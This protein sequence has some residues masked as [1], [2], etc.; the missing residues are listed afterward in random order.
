M[1]KIFFLIAAVLFSS[2]ASAAS[3]TYNRYEKPFIFIENGIEFAVFNDGQFDFNIINSSNVNFNINTRNINFSF[4]TGHNYNA[5]VQ[6]D[7]YGAVVQIESTPVYYDNFGRV[8]R[9]GT[10]RMY[11]N[12]LGYASRIGNLYINYNNYGIYSGHRGAINTYQCNFS[13]RHNYYRLPSRDRCIVNTSPYRRDYT[14]RRYNYNN[15]SRHY[16]ERPRRYNQTSKRV[17]YESERNY[18]K[19]NYNKNVTTSRNNNYNQRRHNNN[20]K[21]YLQRQP[22]RKQTKSYSNRYLN[23]PKKVVKRSYTPRRTYASNTN[24]RTYKRK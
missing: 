1:K 9:I 23:T 10:T 15:Y 3:T 7:N 21:K 18:N 4:N 14:V 19:R 24:S 2:I 5:F 22:V 17:H 11:Y 13:P 16:A 12:N 20:T 6:Y 8:T